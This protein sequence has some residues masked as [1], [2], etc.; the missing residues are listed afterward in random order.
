MFGTTVET[1]NRGRR[2]IVGGLTVALLLS[3]C[4]GAP[5]T[6]GEAEVA[7]TTTAPS[8]AESGT[9]PSVADA[10][11]TGATGPAP[12]D[13]TAAPSTTSTTTAAPTTCRS[14]RTTVVYRRIEGVPARSTSLD[15]HNPSG[16]CGMPVWVWVHGGG[17]RRGDKAGQIADK[18]RLAAQ[19]GWLLVSVNYRLT[20]PANPVGARFPDHYE[21]VA[22][23]LAWI[24]QRIVPFG[25]DPTRVAVFGHSAG[26]DIVSN[27][28]V[29]PD[30][31]ASRGVDRRFIDCIGLLDTGGY[32]KVAA[33]A[34]DNRA[35][36][37]EGPMWEAA[38][39]NN[40]DYLVATSAARQIQPS[41][42]MPATLVALRG[43]D[44]RRA[45]AETMVTAVRS[46]GAATTVVDAR[47]LTH[48]EVNTRIGA[49]GDTVMTPPVVGFLRSCF[50]R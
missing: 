37:I 2:G 48:G 19:Q 35:S 16:A 18:V 29:V 12:T 50:A 41:T 7:S 32:D 6:T 24:R 26:A 11:A 38:L 34:A 46:T 45:I 49:A 13:A 5:A 31:L 44:A 39:G 1:G 25:G 10:T 17:Y 23:A 30:H 28:A 4:G 40:P 21:D 22:A 15:V 33:L 14:G 42:W 27:V 9:D 43:S 3:A 36:E 20:D 47:G 8:A